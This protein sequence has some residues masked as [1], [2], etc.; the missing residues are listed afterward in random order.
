MRLP[1]PIVRIANAVTTLALLVG[2]PRPPYTRDNALVVETIGRRSGKRRRLPV[3]FLDDGGRIIV[4]VEDGQRAQWVRNALAND[5]RLRVHLR[6]VWR[7]ARLRILDVDP[8]SYLRR[9]NRVHAA[10]VRLESTAPEVVEISP[11]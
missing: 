1:Q 7:P 2:I 11:E 4:V 10:F 6:G 9:M 5:G 8:E 3:G